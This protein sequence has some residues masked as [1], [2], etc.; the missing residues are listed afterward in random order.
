VNNQIKIELCLE[1]FPQGR[2]FSQGV[3]LWSEA[4]K[5]NHILYYLMDREIKRK[6]GNGHSFFELSIYKVGKY[7]KAQQV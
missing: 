1:N 2:I 6:S 7:T 5:M 3:G 4:A